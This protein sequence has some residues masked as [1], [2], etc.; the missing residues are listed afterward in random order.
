MNQRIEIVKR[1]YMEQEKLN[2]KRNKDL[3]AT[4][5]SWEYE[6]YVHRYQSL[7]KSYGIMIKA[8]LPDGL[9]R[10]LKYPKKQQKQYLLQLKSYFEIC[11]KAQEKGVDIVN[12]TIQMLKFTADSLGAHCPEEFLSKI[13]PG[14]IV[15]VFDYQNTQLFRNMKFFEIS[16]YTINDFFGSQWDALY[17]RAESVTNK[18]I[19]KVEEASRKKKCIPFDIE[20]HYMREKETENRKVVKVK[21]KH[22][23][24]FL[25][26]DKPIAWAASSSAEIIF[27]KT[28]EEAEKL[29]FFHNDH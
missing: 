17:E 19:A 4:K 7:L 16:D 25:K 27:A 21:L 28:D 26:D 3:A 6:S 29:V 15:E 14:D 8:F 9:G 5:Y 20:D 24:P 18:L 1:A 12:D 23:S 13:E 22:I 11:Q 2:E 10:F